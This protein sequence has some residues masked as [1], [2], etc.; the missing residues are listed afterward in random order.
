MSELAL[1]QAFRAA[2]R[3]DWVL[4][5]QSHLLALPLSALAFAGLC[6]AGASLPFVLAPHYFAWVVG[7]VWASWPLCYFD[8]LAMLLGPV[9]FYRFVCYY[10]HGASAS[11][12]A[13]GLRGAWA[14]Q[15]RHR[16]VASALLFATLPTRILLRRTLPRQRMSQLEPPLRRPRLG[17]WRWLLALIISLHHL[18]FSYAAQQAFCVRAPWTLVL[19]NWLGPC[20]VSFGYSPGTKPFGCSELRRGH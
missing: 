3:R 7:S 19:P 13:A 6:A 17:L 1:E 16:R 18:P 15:P 12:L 4:V 8:V 20:Q 9:F 5:G 2:R 14:S 10:R 11:L